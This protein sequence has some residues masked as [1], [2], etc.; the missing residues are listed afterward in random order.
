M[1]G[2]A[3]AVGICSTVKWGKFGRFW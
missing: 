2:Y 1:P 3:C